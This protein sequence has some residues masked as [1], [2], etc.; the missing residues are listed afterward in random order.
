M[1]SIAEARSIRS[2]GPFDGQERR[3]PAEVAALAVGGRREP[4]QLPPR[5][6]DLALRLR[7]LLLR[8]D[9][10]LLGLLEPEPA[11]L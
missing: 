10:G 5:R 2:C 11:P 4:A 3:Q 1:E 7:G 8:D 6:V 9:G